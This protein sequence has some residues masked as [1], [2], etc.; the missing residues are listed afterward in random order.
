MAWITWFPARYLDARIEQR[1]FTTIILIVSLGFIGFPV[2][3]GD[4]VALA[5]ESA[6]A[7]T[8]LLL[9][10]L[11]SRPSLVMLL[12]V[13]WVLHGA[14]DLV[15]LL[16]LVPVDKPLWVVQLCVPYDWLIAGYLFRRVAAWRNG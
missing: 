5:W 12:P 9:I 3:Q 7:A 16:G 11:S 6:V 15:Y 13:V 8:L 10:F 2:Q 14:W 4:L 1:F